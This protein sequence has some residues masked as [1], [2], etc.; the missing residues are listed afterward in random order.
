MVDHWS[1][2]TKRVQIFRW[3]SYL[4]HTPPVSAVNN[5][6]KR[7]RLIKVVAPVRPNGL[8]SA[9]IPNVQL[10]V[11][12]HEALDVETLSGR[13]VREGGTV[14]VTTTETMS[15]KGTCPQQ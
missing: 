1:T 4:I 11:F 6:N 2:R 5:V 14:N 3:G 13:Q 10:E 7:V 8:L 15:D 12:V 9:D